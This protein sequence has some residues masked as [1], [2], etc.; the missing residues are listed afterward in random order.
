M[1]IT[2]TEVSK[3]VSDIVLADDNFATIVTAI[4]LGRW[5]FDNIKKY[6]TYLLQCNLVEIM[7]LSAAVLLGYPLPLL[8]TQILYINLA[9]DGLP[10]IALGV[11][12]PDHDIMHRPP[13]EP[14]ESIFTK[15]VKFFLLLA[16]LLQ[17]P[18]LFGVF[19]WSL[20][21]GIGIAR[22]RLF[23]GLFSLN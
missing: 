14:K 23:L 11:S 2:G 4:E 16:V 22:T 13:R 15:E 20:P 21:Q 17:V 12:P 3:E 19:L 18:I 5:I 6:L 10:T 8:P 9:T 1:G 7:V